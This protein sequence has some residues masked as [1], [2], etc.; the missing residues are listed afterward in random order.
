M[1]S[2]VFVKSRGRQALDDRGV[3]EAGGRVVD[4][5]DDGELA[6]QVQPRRP[7]APVLVLHPA[8]P[9]VQAA[10]RGVGR[11]DLGHRRGDREHEDRDQRPAERH[12]GLARPG[13]AVVVE[14]D[15][16]GQDADDREADREVAEAAHRAEQLLRVAELVEVGDVLLDDVVA[17]RCL[18]HREP[19]S[20][21]RDRRSGWPTGAS[22]PTFFD[23][24]PCAAAA[25]GGA[26]RGRGDRVDDARRGAAW[27]RVAPWGRR[28]DGAGSLAGPPSACPRESTERPGSVARP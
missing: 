27:P 17:R 23:A 18:G 22:G 7:P 11:G 21:R 25:Q 19:P 6:D 14:D 24:G 3:D 15:R 8:G 2:V 16:A 10:G 5:G 26:P 1:I 9:V 13:Q 4:A 28:V 20:Q 12:G